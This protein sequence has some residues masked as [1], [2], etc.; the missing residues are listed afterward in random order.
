MPEDL[1]VKIL[2]PLVNIFRRIAVPT[3]GTMK[4]MVTLTNMCAVDALAMEWARPSKGPAIAV[5]LNLSHNT[6]SIVH[7]LNPRP[8]PR[9]S[10]H[11]PGQWDYWRQLTLYS[12]S[13]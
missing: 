9:S 11:K 10:N 13:N 5:D 12:L 3:K 2:P 6:T 1:I 8:D 7:S 4:T